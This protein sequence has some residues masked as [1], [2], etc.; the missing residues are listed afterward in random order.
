MV[1]RKTTNQIDINIF[2]FKSFKGGNNSKHDKNLIVSGFN[3]IS[4][5]NL[6]VK[7]IKNFYIKTCKH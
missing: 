5:K 3:L 2:L 1:D 6:T 7:F 4:V